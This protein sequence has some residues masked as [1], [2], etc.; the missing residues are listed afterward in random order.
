[1]KTHFAKP[2]FQESGFTVARDIVDFYTNTKASLQADIIDNDAI[3]GAGDSGN[4]LPQFTANVYPFNITEQ[5][6]YEAIEV[7]NDT[8]GASVSKGG[9]GDFFEFGF[10]DDLADVNFNRI[11]FRGFSSGNPPDQ[12]SVPTIDDSVAINPGEEEGGLEAI[13][14]NIRGTWGADGIGTLPFL[15]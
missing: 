14:G 5:S 15:S 9:G 12:A 4:E 10:V 13:Q 6:H 1:M 2:F 11:K 7:T 8:M 3:F